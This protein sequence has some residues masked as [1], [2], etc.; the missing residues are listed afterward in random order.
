MPN[1]VYN[2]LTITGNAEQ[3]ERFAEQAARPGQFRDGEKSLS[4][5]SFWNFIKPDESIMGEYW[6]EEPRKAT[7]AEAM[8]HDTNHWYDWNVRNWG[9]KWDASN[10]N[11]EDWDGELAYDFDTPWSPPV[12]AL[13]A[14][15]EQ[16]PQLVIEMRS[17]E[18]QGWGMEYIADEDG[19]RLIKEWDIPDTHEESIERKGWCNCE[20]MHDDELE[21]AYADCPRKKEMVSNG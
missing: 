3:V 1:W 16:F 17:V 4:Q 2:T 20:E 11:F 5:L 21:W 15:C 14:M 7:L 10:V 9:C 19:V 12:E 18:E 6:G 13:D 8:K